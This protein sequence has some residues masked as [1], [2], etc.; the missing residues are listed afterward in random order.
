MESLLPFGFVIVIAVA[1]ATQIFKILQEYELS[2][3]HI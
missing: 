3:I 1:L 2:L